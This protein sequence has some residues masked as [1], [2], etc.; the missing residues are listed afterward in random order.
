[1]FGIGYQGLTRERIGP[2]LRGSDG[3][4]VRTQELQNDVGSN[5]LMVPEEGDKKHMM[6]KDE[7]EEENVTNMMIGKP[8]WIRTGRRLPPPRG[9]WQQFSRR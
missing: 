9:T 6:Q 8:S 1:M 4:E 5:A 3:E 2:Q 7:K